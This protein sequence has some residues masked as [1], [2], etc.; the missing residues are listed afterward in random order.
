MG[1]TDKRDAILD[2]VKETFLLQGYR[3]L[4]LSAVAEAVGITKSALYHYFPN[5]KAMV[6]A[7]MQREMGRNQQAL[8]R[9]ADRKR[10]PAAKLEAMLHARFRSLLSFEGK[11]GLSLDL[12]IDVEPLAREVRELFVSAET[13]LFT[14]VLRQGIAA[15]AFRIGDSESTARMLVSIFRGLE[16]ECMLQGKV[17]NLRKKID[18]LIDLLQHGL[19]K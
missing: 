10:D 12:L 3:K 15:G 5:K 18:A 8:E 4:T 11:P 6:R 16:E 13:D 14:G 7:V 17:R 9:A 19:L 2:A 1:K